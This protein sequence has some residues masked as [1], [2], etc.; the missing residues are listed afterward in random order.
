VNV[1]VFLGWI[2]ILTQSCLGYQK[3]ETHSRSKRNNGSVGYCG[4]KFRSKS[5]GIVRFWQ[6]K[7]EIVRFWTNM[8]FL[9]DWVELNFGK[10]NSPLP[11]FEGR[12]FVVDNHNCQIDRF[13]VWV[14]SNDSSGL[15]L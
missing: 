9:S 14:W 6:I 12:T 4:N 5:K 15:D 2:W 7:L 8:A 1:G 10:E 13:L 11:S 3:K